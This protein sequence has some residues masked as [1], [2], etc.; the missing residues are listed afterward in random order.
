MHNIT[1]LSDLNYSWSG[2]IPVRWNLIY[3]ELLVQIE[4]QV[5][6]FLIFFCPAGGF[7]PAFFVEIVCTPH[8]CSCCCDSYSFSRR[9]LLKT[10]PLLEHLLPVNE[11]RMLLQSLLEQQQELLLLKMCFASLLPLVRCPHQKFVQT[12]NIICPQ[13]IPLLVII[14]ILISTVTWKWKV[15]LNSKRLLNCK[16][17][18]LQC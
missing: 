7:Y 3:L 13:P 10:R 17:I 18:L 8:A 2:K 6:S 11:C 16:R 14:V 1:L 15:F 12:S 9:C 5:Q 4:R